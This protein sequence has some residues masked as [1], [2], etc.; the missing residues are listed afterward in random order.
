M[1]RAKRTESKD[2][3]PARPGI[4]IEWLPLG[5]IEGQPR[6][7]KQHDLGLIHKSINR[8][9]FVD[10][11]ILDDRTGRLV[12]GHGRVEALREKK[13]AGESAPL[14]IRIDPDGEWLVPCVRGASFSSDSEAEAYTI[15]NNRAVEKGG[16]DDSALLAVLS[17]LAEQDGGLDGVGYDHEE[18]DG[19]L[20]ALRGDYTP[21]PSGDQ[22]P[23]GEFPA[24]DE[25]IETQYCCPKCG[26]E[27]SGKPK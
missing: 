14:R 11:V 4:E 18:I 26:Y 21:G 16:W 7:P 25:T 9:G 8:F 20:E 13:S 24:F 5:S 23:P 2:E 19:M 3:A 27:W 6:N 1:A 15:V 22:E 12:A 10:P 17:D